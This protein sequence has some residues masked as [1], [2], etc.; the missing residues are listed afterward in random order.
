MKH[1]AWSFV[2]ISSAHSRGRRIQLPGI[3]IAVLIAV[4]ILGG[5]GLGRCLFFVGSYA[6]AKFGVYNERRENHDLLLK[7]RFLSKLAE[8]REHS[9][10][11]LVEFEDRARLRYGMNTISEDVRHAGIG[12]RPSSEEMLLASLEDPVILEAS[13]IKER[14]SSLIRQIDLQDS[15]FS[16][17]AQHV[18]RQHDRWAQ[19]PA[20]W[21]TR[22][23]RITSHYGYRFHPFFQRTMFH[24]GLDIADQEWTPIFAT[25]DGI[26]S[27]VGSKRDFGN[28]VEIDH[29]GNGYKTI[30]AHL[31]HTPMVEGK[32]VKRGELIGY[33]G[34]TGR[35]T[36]TH[37]HYEIRHM[38]RHVNP[39]AFLLPEDTVVD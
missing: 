12:G 17:M 25:A 35:S 15:T 21:P 16:R 8:K 27:F 39:R 14:I 1:K 19:R 22:S 5:L 26:A 3:A 6:Y 32:V 38:N 34:N 23:R 29:H 11:Q 28:V 10:R 13:L 36:G 2:F 9:A 20:I 7:M 18:I 30:Y 33:M 37:L 31:R 4:F 24:E